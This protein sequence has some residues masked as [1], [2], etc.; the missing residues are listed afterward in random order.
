V[1]KDIHP[2]KKKIKIRTSKNMSYPDARAGAKGHSPVCSSN[3]MFSTFM[4]F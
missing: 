1:L 2:R 4:M 3:Y